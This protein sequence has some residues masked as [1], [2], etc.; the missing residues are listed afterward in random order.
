MPTLFWCIL[1]GLGSLNSTSGRPA[2]CPANIDFSIFGWDVNTAFTVLLAEDD[3]NDRRLFQLA[4]RRNKKPIQVHEVADGMEVIQY[5]KGEGKFAERN[6]FPFPNLLI[7]DLKMP[8]MT[9]LEVLH[10]LRH[11]P[12][13]ARL[14]TVMLS[15]SG[16]DA[17]VAEAY[18]LGANSYFEKPNDFNHF[19]KVLDV[20]FNYWMLTEQTNEY[21]KP[22]P[23]HG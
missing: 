14:C 10:W 18:R 19:I 13:F 20:I 17:D 2:Y 5:L 11:K 12:E 22:P 16:L 15:G 3:P 8:R 6:K 23:M 9:G 4:L 21:L 7:L 1:R